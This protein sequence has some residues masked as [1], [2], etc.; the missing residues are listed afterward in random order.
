MICSTTAGASPTQ[1]ATKRFSLKRGTTVATFAVLA[2]GL[3]PSGAAYNAQYQVPVAYEGA[4]Q[5]P[6]FVK[7]QPAILDVQFM[8]LDSETDP[9]LVVQTGAHS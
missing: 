1:P 7:G 9:E 8:I 6:G 5:K 2:R 3:S 4:S